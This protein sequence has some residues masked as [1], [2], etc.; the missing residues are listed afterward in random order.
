M[1]RPLAHHPHIAAAG[2]SSLGRGDDKMLVHMTPHEV[3][4]LRQLAM[5]AGGDLSINPATGLYEAGFLSSLL[6]MIAGGL[7][8]MTGIGAPLGAAIVGAGDAAITGSWKKGLMA[9][10]GAYGGA[11]LATGL[12]AAGSVANSSADAVSAANAAAPSATQ[13]ITDAA[14]ITQTASAA[15]AVG[16]VPASNGIASLTPPVSAAPPVP[17]TP[18]FPG[19]PSQMTQ[20]YSNSVAAGTLPPTG[21][22]SI[23]SSLAA[24]APT[25]PPPVTPTAAPTPT[26]APPPATMDQLNAAQKATLKALPVDQQ[27]AYL[28]NLGVRNAMQ[29]ASASGV[30]N[31]TFGQAASNMK[32]GLGTLNTMQGWGNLGSTMGTTGM[33]A[34]ALPIAQTLSQFNQSTGVPTNAQT[35]VEY[36]NTVYDPRT[37][38]YSR[39][40][41]TT[42]FAGNG[43]TGAPG[44]GQVANT[45]GPLGS[46]VDPYTGLTA[47]KEGGPI[48]HMASGGQTSSNLQD[49]YKSL[50]S[51]NTSVSPL[52]SVNPSANNAFM[53]N[54]AQGTAPTTPIGGAGMQFLTN[55][56]PQS[57]TN[58]YGYTAPPPGATGA[59]GATGTAATSTGTGATMPAGLRSLMGGMFGGNIAPDASQMAAIPTYTW[60]PATQSFTQTSSGYAGQ[61]DGGGKAAGG[62]IASLNTF[63]GGGTPGLGSYSDGGRALKGPG[64][65]MSDSIPAHIIGNKPQPAALA[66]GEFV[67]PADVV[68]HLGNGSTDAGSRVLYKMMDK[69]RQARTGNPEQGKQI[70]PNKFIP[71]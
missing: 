50:M 66:D 59:T 57:A 44:Q 61:G 46:Y 54:L 17:T 27:G 32:A 35:P 2:L 62:G 10:I 15:P 19:F 8:S 38:T 26:G 14:G 42:Q 13:G 58:P 6:P 36:Y 64:D 7:L 43:Y 1:L 3:G 39:G 56:Q 51:G 12:G 16:T 68:S 22:P 9:G 18:S 49:Y 21:S 31:P 28:Q 60:N 34:T 70:N 29:G 69:V 45:K 23:P 40:N 24:P 4:G 67:I 33:A 65:G 71:A 52:Q 53:A 63:S 20:A 37:Q 55:Q 41:W 11:S 25:P 30:W 5:A 48:K 47:V